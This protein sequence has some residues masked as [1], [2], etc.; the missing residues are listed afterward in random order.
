[1]EDTHIQ[2][3]VY[4][5]YVVIK[6]MI[7]VSGPLQWS[8]FTGIINKEVRERLHEQFDIWLDML[9]GEM[10]GKEGKLDEITRAIFE[11][12]HEL[13][14]IGAESLVEKVHPEE[15]EQK[16]TVCPRC[17]MVLTSRDEVERTVETMRKGFRLGHEEYMEFLN[18]LE[19]V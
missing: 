1:M 9:E 13:T 2:R 11:M 17:G 16:E 4:Y 3:F 18:L 12:R 7:W 14:G 6:I 10:K 19:K 5:C 8:D 15:L